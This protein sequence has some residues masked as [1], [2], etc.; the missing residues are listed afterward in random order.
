MR[1][2]DWSSD[3]CS[4]DLPFGTD[5]IFAGSDLPD[6]VFH[7][8]I[9]EDYWAP[10]PPSTV[11]ALAGALILCNLSASNIT[12]GKADERKLLSA[13][14]SARCC[15]AYVFAA[16]GPGESTTDLAWDGQG[17]IY[18]LGELLAESGR[19]DLEPELCVA[20]LDVQRL[21]LD[22]MRMGTFKIGR[23]HVCTP[24]TN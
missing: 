11:G 19:F 23:A 24:V 4:S 10:R 9:C 13:A 6:F 5:L 16:S 12:I 18:E 17:S 8:E 15:A 2:S 7:V 3:V 14:Q 22:R 21:R 20:D 1:I